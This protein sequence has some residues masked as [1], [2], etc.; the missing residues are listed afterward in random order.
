M[1]RSVCRI[2]RLRMRRSVV[3]RIVEVLEAF[4]KSHPSY[5]PK[6]L[7]RKVTQEIMASSWKRLQGL[8]VILA[9]HAAAT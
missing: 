1:R 2:G 7:Q 3:R 6:V 4:E 8:D 9:E 5:L